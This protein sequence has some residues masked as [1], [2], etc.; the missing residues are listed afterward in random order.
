MATESSKP[1]VWSPQQQAFL[2]WC[3]NGAGSAVVIAVAGAGKT[4][5]AIEGIKKLRGQTAMMAFN[6]RIADEIKVKLE[7]A[8]MDWK[9]AQGG[10]AHSFGYSAFRK[11]FGT[12]EIDDRKVNKIID[13]R[14]QAMEDGYGDSTFF[15]QFG[16]VVANLVSYAKQ[17]ALGVVGSIDDR[18][19]W[20]RLIEHYD[21]WSD[22]DANAIR[23]DNADGVLVTNA[24]DILNR[25]NRDTR[26]IDFND[27]IYLP[28]LLR[29]KFWQ[30]DNVVV[31]EAQDTNAAR[32]ILARVMLKRGGRLIAIGDP[33]Q[34]IN[35]FAGADN[36]AL[37]HIK[38][39]FNCIELPLTV[40]YRCP[41]QVVKFAQNWASHIQPHP[42][43]PEGTVSAANV[44][45]IFEGRLKLDGHDAILCRNNKPLVALA[46]KLI[47]HRIG[48]KIEGRDIGIGLLKLAHRWSRV[49][50]LDGLRERLGVYLEEQKVRLLAKKQE[51]RFALLEDQIECLLV[52][53]AQCVA[54]KQTTL[55]AVDDYI[56]A[57]FG[58]NVAGVVTLSSIHKSKGR[59]WQRVL[60]L[61]RFTTC[62][63]RWARQAWEQEQE[64]N[65]QYVAAT[66]AM[67]D[68]VDLTM[69]ETVDRRETEE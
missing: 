61:N 8:G 46:M 48:A 63:S 56:N 28:L 43:A 66:R 9:R 54:D 17:A 69:A 12:P 38:H 11:S 59:E 57:L 5:V 6:K 22:A 16:G 62:P 47:K 13:G 14:I 34:A 58:D 32:R 1:F 36:D 45:D 50:D 7:K 67:S 35:G 10:T 24:I 2:D 30:F 42:E 41:K 33:A 4:T 37:D 52:I 53:I 15:A 27:M 31:D 51:A 21:V 3:L 68:L 26:T 25:S 18:G 49:N 64:N 44:E 55:T 40:S 29:A 19:A 20:L 39:D 60:W 65:L 23:P